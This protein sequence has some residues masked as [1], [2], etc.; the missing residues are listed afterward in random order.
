MTKPKEGTAQRPHQRCV[1][2]PR[3]GLDQDPSADGRRQDGAVAEVV[4]HRHAGDEA[5]GDVAAAGGGFSRQPQGNGREQGGKG[6]ELHAR[7]PEHHGAQQ[8]GGDGDGCAHLGMAP[9]GRG[10]E[11][12]GGGQDEQVGHLQGERKA[13][14]V[15]VGLLGAEAACQDGERRQGHGGRRAVPAVPRDEAPGQQVATAAARIPTGT[16][17]SASCSVQCTGTA[18]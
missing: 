4:P 15:E 16:N 12:C 11:G 9:H 5:E 10:D 2:A 17:A 6:G 8:D 18:T 14:Q 3:D 13:E 1:A 7:P